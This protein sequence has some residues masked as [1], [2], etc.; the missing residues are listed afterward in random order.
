ME[1]LS[2]PDPLTTYVQKEK[3]MENKKEEFLI[4]ADMEIIE[5]EDRIDMSVIG[6][7]FGLGHAPSAH[8]TN[9]SDISFQ[10]GNCEC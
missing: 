6:L 9:L 10:N 7:P 5:L 8:G 1:Y 3:F 2:T 4:P